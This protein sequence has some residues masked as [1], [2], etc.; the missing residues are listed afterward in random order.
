[1]KVR[2][3]ILALLMFFSCI[4]HGDQKVDLDSP[5]GWA[6]AFMTT[7]AQ[8]LGHVPPHSVNIR[9]ISISA[10]LSSI[11]RLSKEQQRI[12]FGGFKDEDL[13]K[14]PAFGRLRANIGLPWN[15]DAEI[16]WTPPLQINDSKPDHLW[17]AALSKPLFN[18]EKISMGLRL[19]LLRG[20]VTASVTCSEDTINFAPYTPQNTAGCV[21]LSEDKLQMDHEG[22]EVFLSFNNSSKILPWVSLASSNI[23]NSVE[24]DAPLE[25]GRERA[26]VY[27]SGTIQTLSFGFNYDI[28]ENW[29]LNAASSYTPLDVQRPND[30][31]DNDDFWN[32][33]VGLTIRY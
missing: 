31:S 9:D 30:N 5:E 10:E 28:R 33:R 20:G 26:T 29:S 11:P 2:L 32:V 3:I 15:L 17:G 14:S 24:I 18:N 22:V 23:D 19:F 7:S 27:S 12:G 8:N 13:N 1:M 4:A 16:S 25:V 21:G 6:M